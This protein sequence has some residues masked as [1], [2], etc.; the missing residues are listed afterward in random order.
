MHFCSS[1]AQQI[2]LYFFG[3][4]QSHSSPI[5]LKALTH[6]QHQSLPPPAYRIL[7]LTLSAARSNSH[8][9]TDN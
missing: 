4:L 3:S 5:L 1:Y 6:V 8:K 7:A 9:P 2:R